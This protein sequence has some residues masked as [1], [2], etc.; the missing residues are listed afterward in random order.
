M[1]FVKKYL[2]N[3]C[4]IENFYEEYDALKILKFIFKDI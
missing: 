1:S 3:I 4:E 2:P